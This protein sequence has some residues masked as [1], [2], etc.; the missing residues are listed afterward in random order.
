ML[1]LYLLCRKL[2]KGIITRILEDR[3]S[4]ISVACCLEG[5]MVLKVPKEAS[6]SQEGETPTPTPWRKTYNIIMRQQCILKF[7]D[8]A[9]KVFLGMLFVHLYIIAN[10]SNYYNTDIDEC[11]MPVCEQVCNN[12][13]GSFGCD[14][15]PGFNLLS[16]GRSCEGISVATY[17]YTQHYYCAT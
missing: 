9:Y 6:R 1:Q 2:L 16:N 11:V 10:S 17:T 5:S 3:H 7:T 15:N 8:A 14:C 12:T 4:K 13:D